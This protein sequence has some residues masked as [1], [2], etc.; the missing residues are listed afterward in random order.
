MYMMYISWGADR[1]EES[2]TV[3]EP[4]ETVTRYDTMASAR[5]HFGQMLNAAESGNLA[6]VSRRGVDSALVRVG[7]L[8]TLLAH[9]IRPFE[10]QVVRENGNWVAYLPGLPLAVEEPDLTTAIDALVEAAREYVAD[11]NDHLHA[12]VNHRDNIDFVQFVELSSDD[13][14]REWMTAAEG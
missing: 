10:P 7:R 5:E 11:W 3:A 12:A 2:M 14:L 13:Q 4:I 9:V 8:R 6:V 1:I